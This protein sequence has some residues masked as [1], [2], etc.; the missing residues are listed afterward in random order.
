VAHSSLRKG[1]TLIEVLVVIAIIAILVGL[2]VPGVQKVRSAAD[3]AACQNNL[4]QLGIALH[5]YQSA[6]RTFPPAADYRA[7]A[8]A[9]FALLAQL[10]PYVEQD[11]VGEL[12]HVDKTAAIQTRI[13]LFACPS[14]LN[15]NVPYSSTNSS[16]VTTTRWPITYGFNFSSWLVYDWDRGRG[17]DGAFV[18]NQPLPPRAYVDGL[19]NTLAISEVKALTPFAPNTG[20]PT[21]PGVAIPTSP[22]QVV[23]YA[24]GAAPKLTGHL[25]WQD[26][27]VFH[28]GFTTTF[29]PNT[30]VILESG[31]T[32]YDID[33]VSLTEKAGVKGVTYASVTSRSYHGG[34]VNTLFMDGSVHSITDGI[35]IQTWRALGTRAGE[36]TIE[37]FE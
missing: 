27:K 23:G 30:A 26:P 29:T 36:D 31:D 3:R 13:A 10:F 25:E 21:S 8:T 5:N 11:A 28:S 12:L 17:G 35:S 37:A 2:L 22:A 4:K 24:G 14:D 19:S 34:M 16:G 9:N 6:M 7:S 33:M 15:A 32:K 20:N 1:F 18:I